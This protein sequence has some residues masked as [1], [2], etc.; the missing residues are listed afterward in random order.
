MCEWTSEASRPHG[1]QVA[2]EIFGPAT[3]V[4]ERAVSAASP[5]GH[6]CLCGTSTP[7]KI[8]SGLACGSSEV[9]PSAISAPPSPLSTL[10]APPSSLSTLSHCA[11]SSSGSNASHDGRRCRK[12]GDTRRAPA[13]HTPLSS[14]S[15]AAVQ[16]SAKAGK[17]SGT[18]SA[19]RPSISAR[20]GGRSD[21]AAARFTLRSSG[22][23]PDASK[24]RATTQP[25]RCKPPRSS[26][27]ARAPQPRQ[28]A[29]SALA[30][31]SGV[32]P[33][34]AGGAS[35]ARSSAPAGETSPV[36]LSSTLLPSTLLPS[37]L[38]LMRPGLW[39]A[40]ATGV[41]MALIVMT[42]EAWTHTQGC[43]R[44]RVHGEPAHGYLSSRGV[45]RQSAARWASESRQHQNHGSIRITAASESR[46]HQNTLRR[47]RGRGPF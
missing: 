41:C 3:Q 24:T 28:R 38:E 32:H 14:P 16:R 17:L 7:T 36:A 47:H 40:A 26:A 27:S 15:H 29:A 12:C 33:S 42:S 39:R 35:Q 22:T 10:S 5:A 9:M 1:Q 31:L 25:E 37:T 8:S 45:S 19:R 21:K 13:A 46:Q 20:R 30:T 23:S 6:V 18:C 34:S 2:A 44:A 11:A 43:E 4:W